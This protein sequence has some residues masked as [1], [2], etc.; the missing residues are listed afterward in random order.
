[1]VVLNKL[2]SVFMAA[3]LLLSTVSWTIEKHLCMGR[4]MDVALFSK[5]A[6]C[7]M[8]MAALENSNAT[9]HCC[10]DDK[11]TITGQEDLQIS[12]DD[13]EVPEQH[14][15]F[16]FTYAYAHIFNEVAAPSLL[17]THHPPPLLT[18]DIQLLDEVFLI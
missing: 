12:W 10:D 16:N 13:L 2:F 4:V 17:R 9:Y 11:E 7:G 8:G 14:L 1:M 18:K 3:L 15:L 5:A 6:D